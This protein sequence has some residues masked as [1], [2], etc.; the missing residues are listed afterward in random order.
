MKRSLKKINGFVGA[1]VES[2]GTVGEKGIPAPE[3]H[4]RMFETDD[5]Q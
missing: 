1:I 3:D 5:R 2:V 4:T